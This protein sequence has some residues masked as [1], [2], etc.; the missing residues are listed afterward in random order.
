MNANALFIAGSNMADPYLIYLDGFSRLRRG[1]GFEAQ[2]FSLVHI[3]DE[4]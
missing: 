4:F 3:L 1:Y 2:I